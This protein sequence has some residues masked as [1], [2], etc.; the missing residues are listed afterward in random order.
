MESHITIPKSTLRRFADVET[1]KF[2]Y[3]DFEQ[4]KIR[5]CA[6]KSYNKEEGYYKAEYEHWLD[7]NVETPMGVL[8]KAI[9]DFEKSRG[10][11]SG[12]YDNI[13]K[14]LIVFVAAQSA[15]MESTV[16]EVMDPEHRNAAINKVLGE[17]IKQGELTPS[18]IKRA[19]KYREQVSSVEKRRDT[20]YTPDNTQ[21]MIRLLEKRYTDHVANFAIIDEAVDASFIIT[22]MHFFQHGNRLIIP[23]APRYAYIL[24][25]K[26]EQERDYLA[27]HE[28]ELVQRWIRLKEPNMVN[29]LPHC[30]A[31]VK[32]YTPHHLIADR[33]YLEKLVKEKQL[34]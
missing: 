27:E 9:D 4:K 14:Q 23:C 11:F 18:A 6:P 17:I 28:G 32:K 20:F 8:Y 2:T 1:K 24:M 7:V 10:V 21:K 3:Y 22:P 12:D 16:E 25:P 30:I 31:A 5:V 15:R 29:F 19:N 13:R 34:D 33:A 26:S